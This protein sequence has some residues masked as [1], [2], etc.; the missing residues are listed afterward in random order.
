MK[1][2]IYA[3]IFALVAMFG[4]VVARV[5]ATVA[6]DLTAITPVITGMAGDL[7]PEIVIIVTALG[8]IVLI[9]VLVNYGFKKLRSVGSK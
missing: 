2:R 5:S 7:V 6:P 4:L 1:R 3:F 8:V 9:G